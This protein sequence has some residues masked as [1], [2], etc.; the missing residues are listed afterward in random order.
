MGELMGLLIPLMP[1]F[2]TAPLALGAVAVVGLVLSPRLRNAF[3][4]WA[5]RRLRG[6]PTTSDEIASLREAVREL[7]AEV[8]RSRERVAY[9]ERLVVSQGRLPA[10][11]TSPLTEEQ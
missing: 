5:E 10:R 11:A 8:A 7:S 3:A 4:E 2:A 6:G 1:L 9:M